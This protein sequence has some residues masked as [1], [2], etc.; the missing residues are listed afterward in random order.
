MDH[1]TFIGEVQ[2]RAE[3]ASRGEALSA[4]RATFQTLA[5]RI[6]EGQATNIA[7]QLPDE[8]ARIIEE[9]ADTTESFGFQEFVGRVAE[10]DE[11]L[12]SE[13]DDRSAAALHARAVIDVLDEAVTEGQIEDLRDQLPGEYDDLFELAEADGAP[14]QP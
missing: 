14:G 3:L 12:G 8:L 11:N 2:N 4:T 7:A 1:D 5:E 10:R 9:E 6:D 13:D